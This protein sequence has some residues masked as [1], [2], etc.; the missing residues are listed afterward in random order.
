MTSP[1]NLWLCQ[2]SPKNNLITARVSISHSVE[3]RIR[4]LLT[5]IL[6]S[7]RIEWPQ[8]QLDYN[9]V[10][11]VTPH[12]L[13]LRKTHEDLTRLLRKENQNR[14]KFNSK[15]NKIQVQIDFK[16]RPPKIKLGTQV[17]YHRTTHRKSLTTHKDALRLN[18]VFATQ[19]ARSK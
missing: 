16:A 7:Q 3:N 14:H 4:A 15:G 2:I 11:K 10:S 8:N 9:T 19:P 6:Q 18:T 5:R 12:N 1:I 17:Q 13:H